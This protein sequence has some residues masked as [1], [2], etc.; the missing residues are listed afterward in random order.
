MSNVVKM[1]RCSGFHHIHSQHV[2][3]WKRHP[4]LRLQHLET[5]T[6][7]CWTGLLLHFLL[8]PLSSPL[9]HFPPLVPLLR[10]RSCGGAELPLPSPLQRSSSDLH[11]EIHKGTNPHR[12]G[13]LERQEVS[14]EGWKTVGRTHCGG[15][16]AQERFSPWT[17][18]SPSFCS[19]LM[20]WLHT[21]TCE[22]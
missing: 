1:W 2:W 4:C 11:P 18:T 8:L 17:P 3:L 13:T 16:A 5:R 21:Q 15:G 9:L 7:G 20:R 22:H 14:R 19:L 12:V 10:P 6:L